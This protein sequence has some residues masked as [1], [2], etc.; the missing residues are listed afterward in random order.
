MNGLLAKGGLER[1]AISADEARKIEP[2]IQ[3]DISGACFTPSDFTGDIHSYSVGLSEACERQGVIFNYRCNIK[4]IDHQGDSIDVSWTDKDNAKFSENFDN[5]VICAGV[6]SR[7]LAGKACRAVEDEIKFGRVLHG[8][9]SK[10][11]VDLI[12]KT[13]PQ[14]RI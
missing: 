10:N 2:A 13:R 7:K 4:D 14:R 3:T 9:Y 6:G 1:H 11:C 5:I 8:G 12:R